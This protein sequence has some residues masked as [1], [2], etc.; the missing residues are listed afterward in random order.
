MPNINDVFPSKFLV[1]KDV[2]RADTKTMPVTVL[3]I[4]V[5]KIGEEDKLVAYFKEIDKPFVLNKTN[6]TAIAQIAHS[7]ESDKWP[8][9]KLLLYVAKVQYQGS[10][11]DAVRIES[12]I[13]AAKK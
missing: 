11:V 12:R 10:M 5:E 9:A 6:A 8:G 3:K 7:D 1:A 2:L 13:E 4:E